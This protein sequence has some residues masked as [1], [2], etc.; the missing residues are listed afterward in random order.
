[1]I[2]WAYFFD[3]DSVEGKL[4]W[5]VTNSVRAVA[6]SEVTSINSKGYVCVGL[7]G[8]GYK[9]HRIVWDM[10]NPDDKL[11]PGD[12][13]DHIDHDKTNNRPANLRKVSRK[14]N[15]RNQKKRATNTS[16]V[17]G[18]YFAKRRNKWVAQITTDGWKRSLGSF[19]T[20]EAATAARLAEE[21][22]YGFHENHGKGDLS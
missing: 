11:Q 18:V 10:L 8:K 2:N 9:V 4:Y 14:V 7:N 1:M 15:S 17:N 16:G 6:G 22:K 20:L 3:Y 5:R 13:V 19:D 21:T 12:E